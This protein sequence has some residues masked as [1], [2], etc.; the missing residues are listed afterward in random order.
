MLNSSF[1]RL[2]PD[3]QVKV[4]ATR[5]TPPFVHSKLVPRVIGDIE[6]VG[7]LALQSHVE[8]DS[9]PAIVRVR[10]ISDHRAGGYGYMLA[11]EDDVVVAVKIVG[12]RNAPIGPRISVFGEILMVDAVSPFV[13]IAM[14]V[15]FNDA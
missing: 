5:G 6:Q 11:I 9:G 2:I 13:V 8:F 1:I 15:L 7:V 3:R 14:G 10:V 12:P 4:A